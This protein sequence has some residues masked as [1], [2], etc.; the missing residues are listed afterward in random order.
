[1]GDTQFL[2]RDG[3]GTIE[4]LFSLQ[5]LVQRPQDTNR[6]ISMYCIHFDRV[7]HHTFSMTLRNTGIDD[8]DSRIVGN[9]SLQQEG[10]V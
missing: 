9:L 10:Q 7:E 3:F 5:V 6:N 8:K 4:T 1:M 2:F